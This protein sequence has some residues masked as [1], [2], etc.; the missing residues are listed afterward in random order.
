MSVALLFLTYGNILHRNHPT[1]KKYL[2]NCRVF[3][4]P[5]HVSEIEPD[6]QQNVISPQIPT[7][8]GD[9]SIVIASLS[10]LSTAFRDTNIQWFVL[11]SEDMFPLRDYNEFQSFLDGQEFS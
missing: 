8:W 10:L 4:H 11:C 1:M 5:K 9:A 7:Q 3:I 2:E 6:F